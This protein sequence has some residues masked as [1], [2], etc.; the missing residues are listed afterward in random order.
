MSGRKLFF[1]ALGILLLF[2]SECFAGTGGYVVGEGDVLKITVYDHPDLE[3]KVRVNGDGQ[4]LMPLLGHVDVAGLTVSQISRKLAQMLADGYLVDPQVNVFIEEY[5]SKKAVIL[6]MVNK[7]GLYELSG[8]T[9]LLELISKAGGLAKDAGN[10]ITIKRVKLGGR[11]EVINIDLK[12]LMEGGDISLNVQIKDKDNVFVSKAGMVY[13]TGE[14]EE[15]DAY[16]I[17][18]GATVIK[19]IALAGGFTGKAAKGKVKIIR[20]VDGKK[21]VLENV[22][23][24]TPILPE[25]VIVV[26]ES[27][28]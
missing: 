24:D 14:V 23:M 13:V 9:T 20:M 16:K 4:I 21:V 27:F 7:P 10:K 6:G 25:D 3:T 1:A 11:K 12:A 5:G 28:F 15:P 19:A 2:F 22:Q 26:P 17:D 8:P 18:E